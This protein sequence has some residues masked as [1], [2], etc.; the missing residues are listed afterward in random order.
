MGELF[1]KVRRAVREN[2]Y[3]FSDHADN[4]LR[5]RALVHWY[6]LQGLDRGKLLIERPKAR[7][8]PVVEVEQ[9]LPDGTSVKAVW[10]YLPDLD[11]AKLVTVHFF[12]R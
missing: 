9:L 3:L 12:D 4:A 1:E 5:D 8:N 6:I 2:R 11:F 10:A 7:P